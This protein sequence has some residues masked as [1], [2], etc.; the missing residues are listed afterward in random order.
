MDQKRLGQSNRCLKRRTLEAAAC[1]DRD[2]RK[3]CSVADAD[4]GIG[5]GQR[6][7]RGGDV[8]PALC[9]LRRN[10]GGDRRRRVDHRLAPEWRNRWRPCRVSMAM[11]C[12]YCARRQSDV[13][14]RGLRGF[15]CRSALRPRR[16]SRRSRRRRHPGRHRGPSD[17]QR[18]SRSR[19]CCSMSCPRISK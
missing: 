4:G 18:P 17:P 19:I 5:L 2:L 13:D 10:A 6:A 12:S 7:L 16:C 3:E 14:G 9:E 11:A 15:Q 8:G 1:R